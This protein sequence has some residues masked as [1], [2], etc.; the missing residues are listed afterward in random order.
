MIKGVLLDYGGTIDTNGVHWAEVLWNTYVRYE[1][2]VSKGAFKEAY[3]FGEK[4]LAINPLIQPHHH[5]LDVLTI[6]LNQQ[7]DYLNSQS[8]PDAQ[9]SYRQLIPAMAKDCSDFAKACVDKAQPVLEQLSNQY[10]LVLVSNFYGNIKSVLKEYGI[11]HFFQDVIESAVV[12]VRKPSSEIFTLGVNALGVH[13][14]ECVAIGDSY[15][16]DIVPAKQA[17]CKTIWLKGE[18][19]EEELVSGKDA[20]EIIKNFSEL[21]GV[22]D[23]GIP[24]QAANTIH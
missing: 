7:F 10:P 2:P 18:G 12:G 14:N 9:S 19:W 20:D 11:L 23:N 21:P 3:V 5:F 6:K 24:Q 17:G 22:L 8:Y 4:S 15:K 16:K 1:I 13:S